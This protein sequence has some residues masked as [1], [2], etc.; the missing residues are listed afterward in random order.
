MIRSSLSSS[1][2]IERAA[3]LADRDGLEHV[4]LAAVARSFDVRSPSLYAHVRDVGA[5]HDGI[6][7]VALSQLADR[8]SEGIA[9]RSGKDALTAFA[10]A[11]RDYMQEHPG[12]WDALRRRAGATAVQGSEA[13]RLVRVTEAV[14]RGYGIAGD[15]RTHAI[16][17]L[18]G[19]LNGFLELERA[20]SFSHRLPAT[21]DT[22][23]HLLSALHLVLSDWTATI[24]NS[25]ESR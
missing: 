19:A 11:H 25:G 20:G 1:A 23:P 14:L 2:V 22:W 21:A 9:G 13:A 4:T 12:R 10:Q 7:N 5:L 8:I 16:R 17:I 18:G 3:E 15:D 24:N 6:T